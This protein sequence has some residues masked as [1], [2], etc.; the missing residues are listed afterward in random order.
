MTE[1]TIANYITCN[2]IKS[3]Y[4]NKIWG[5][6]N[7]H[8]DEHPK[9]FHHSLVVVCCHKQGA[10]S[11]KCCKKWYV[12]FFLNGP[13]PAS[14]LF[15]FV[16]FSHRKDKYSTNLTIIEKSVDGMLGSRTRGGRMEGADESTELWRH[17]YDML[18]FASF[19]L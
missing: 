16:L 11:T 6:R 18:K 4:D 7:K 19:P 17:P 10:N 2:V 3:F 5:G 14:F 13:N 9:V 15:I 8:S 12:N 1:T